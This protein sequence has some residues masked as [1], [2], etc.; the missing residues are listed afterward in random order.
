MPPDDTPGADVLLGEGVLDGGGEEADGAAGEAAL[1]AGFD[2][3]PG[4]VGVLLRL[5]LDGMWV[6]HLFL[7]FFFLFL[8]EWCRSMMMLVLVERL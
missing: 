1:D 5:D 2:G 3:V 4:M 7:F 8:S 6:R